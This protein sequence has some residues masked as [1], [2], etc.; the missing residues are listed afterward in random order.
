MLKIKKF[1]PLLSI[2]I[3]YIALLIFF[4]KYNYSQSSSKLMVLP[5]LAYSFA[6]SLFINFLVSSICLLRTTFSSSRTLMLYSVRVRAYIINRF[7]FVHLQ[8]V[9]G[10]NNHRIGR[11]SY[12]N[13]QIVPSHPNHP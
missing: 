5:N 3:L 10:R 4:F 7:I 13:H 8:L 6:F 11:R 2:K 1:S 12:R 9:F